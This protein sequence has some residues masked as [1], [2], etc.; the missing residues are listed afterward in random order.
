MD[1]GAV[2]KEMLFS[3]DCVII[4][5][6]GGFVSN[7]QPARI[8]RET[9][10]FLPPTKEVGFNPELIHNDGMLVHYVMMDGGFTYDEARNQIDRYVQDLFLRLKSGERVFL[11]GIGSFAVDLEDQIRFISDPGVN[12]LVDAFGLAPF[13]FRELPS[14]SDDLF[15][16]S[17]LFR[18]AQ[19]SARK[20]LPG[21]PVPVKN[22]MKQ[23]TRIAIAVPLLLA[24]S[25]LPFNARVTQLLNRHPASLMPTPSLYHLNYPVKDSSVERREILFPIQDT[26]RPSD[27]AATDTLA[28]TQKKT[29][30]PGPVPVTIA[31]PESGR[32]PIIAGSFKARANAESLAGQLSQK[33][34]EGR[35]FTAAN[36]FFR[37]SIQS[38]ATLPEAD[39]ALPRLRQREPAM[40][41][42]VL[43]EAI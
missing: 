13:H 17:P 1:V 26:V 6:F 27:Q 25:L 20:L 4:P 22:T 29:S 23:A 35:V 10:T 43:R 8:Q 21:S 11:E 34:F 30:D 9:S 38:F 42:W 32:F 18:P 16:R 14:A 41:L 37:V 24:F 7:Y 33:G 3:E 31:E 2:I 15:S 39:A 36:G 28:E 40:Q 12:F 19:P 5:G